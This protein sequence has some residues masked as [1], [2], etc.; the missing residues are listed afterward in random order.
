MT[1]EAVN[2]SPSNGPVMQ[3]PF[4][5]A[6]HRMHLANR[7]QPHAGTAHRRRTPQRHDVGTESDRRSPVTSF[8]AQ[9]H[10]R[11]RPQPALMP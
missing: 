3:P 6:E 7:R 5:Q 2:S 10:L 1:V 4:S 9:A 11:G 8:E